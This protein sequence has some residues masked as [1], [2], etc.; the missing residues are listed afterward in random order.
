MTEPNKDLYDASLKA[1]SNCGV[2]E[3]LAEKASEIVAKDN[4][5]ETNLGRSDS[6]QQTINQILPYLNGGKSNE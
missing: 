6:E 5:N 4:P 3:E 2:P 1:L